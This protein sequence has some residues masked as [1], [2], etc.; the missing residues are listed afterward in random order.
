MQ[1]ILVKVKKL[2]HA[3]SG[4]PYYATEGSAGMDLAAAVA[5]PVMIPAGGQRTIPTGL[6]IQIPQSDIVGLVYSRS[7]LAAKYGLTLANSVGVIDSD[8]TGEILCVMANH[9]PRDV[10]INPGDRIA[11]IVFMP[12]C[13]AILQ[14]VAVLDETDRGSGGFGSTGSISKG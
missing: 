6:A 12:L 4:L 11:Q 13:R 9:G 3:H 5:E 14:E 2:P 8:Y 10:N 7:G 1:N